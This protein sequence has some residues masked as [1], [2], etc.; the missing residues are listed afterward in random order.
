MGKETEE[1]EKKRRHQIERKQ[2]Q[3]NTATAFSLKVN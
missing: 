1:D 3:R 2:S